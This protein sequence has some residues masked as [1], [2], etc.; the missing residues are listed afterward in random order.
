MAADGRRRSV[1]GE[2]RRGVADALRDATRDAQHGVLPVDRR[3]TV[4][5]WMDAWLAMTEPTVRPST[6]ASYRDVSA[7]YIVPAIGRESLARLRPEQVARMLATIRADHPHLSTTTV[8]YVHVVLRAALNRA[9]RMGRAHRNVATLVTPPAKARHEVMPMTSTE[10]RALLAHMAQP[11]V[12]PEDGR[13]LDP[14]RSQRLAIYRMA[15]VTGMR[16]GEVLGLRWSDVDMDGGTVT[17]RHT[18]S[19]TGE[20]GDPKTDSGRRT[21]VLDP[22]TVG[23][24]RAH[25]TRQAKERLAAGTRWV[26]ADHVFA[27]REGRALGARNVLRDYHRDLG[28]AGLPHRR[29]HDLRHTAATMLIEGGVDISVVSKLLGHSGIAITGPDLRPLDP[30]VGTA[31]GRP[32]AGHPRGLTAYPYPYPLPDVTSHPPV[33]IG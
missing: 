12:S 33:D 23:I 32:H 21:I 14:R 20:L 18:L 5:Q 17:V 9:V 10:A 19:P 8:R 11:V 29:F 25:R 24:L 2:T 3:L 30:G 1:Y 22:D 15:I 13:P 31:G 27:T 7:R 6:I 16:E 28:T 4:A 26:D